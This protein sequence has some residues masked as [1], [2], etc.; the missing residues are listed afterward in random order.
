MTDDANVEAE[1]HES[2]PDG[3]LVFRTAP[4]AGS[5]TTSEGET[6]VDENVI[7]SPSETLI[8][9]AAHAYAAGV[10]EIVQG[11]DT[12]DLAAYGVQSQEEGEAAYAAAQ[13]DGR[14]QEGQELQA[15]LEQ[16]ARDRGDMAVVVDI[17]PEGEASPDA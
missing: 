8:R 15:A 1:D 5:W 6:Y 2:Y 16:E 4:N 13:E 10:I 7:E 11:V 3:A 17:I 9:D 12:E 14:W